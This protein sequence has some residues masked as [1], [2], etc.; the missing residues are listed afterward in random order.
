MIDRKITL[1]LIL[2]IVVEAGCVFAWAGATSAR[3][4][5]V[6][7]RAFALANLAERVAR[8]EEKIDQAG[9]QLGRIERKL[10]A[11]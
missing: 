6:E 1:A 7:S 4:N 3:L 10:D 5:E 11:N 8:V 9:Q 2:A